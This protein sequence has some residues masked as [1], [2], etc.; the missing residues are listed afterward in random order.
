M[1]CLVGDPSFSKTSPLVFINCTI[2]FEGAS[3][4]VQWGS[5]SLL[6]ASKSPKSIIFSLIFLNIFEYSFSDTRLC[7]SGLYKFTIVVL[8]FGP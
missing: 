3:S 1:S 5:H 8:S 4:I 6:C 7:P 2:S